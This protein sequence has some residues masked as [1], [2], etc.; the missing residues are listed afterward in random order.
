MI[1]ALNAQKWDHVFFTGSVSVGRIVYEAAAKNLTPVTLELGGKNPTI[2]D[3][4]VDIYLAAK[5]ICWGKFWNAGQTCIAPDYVL[6]HKSIE[7][8]FLEE[9]VKVI[10]QFYGE[11][12]Q[13]SE[14]FARIISKDHTKRLAKLFEQGKVVCGGKIDEAT[15]YVA[16]TILTEVKLDG[17]LMNDEIFGPVL[18]VIPVDSIDAAIEFLDS[19]PLPLALYF[20]GASS[21]T[22]EKVLANTRS[23]AAGMNDVLL[24]FTNSGLPFG[25]VGESGTG[26]YHG[27]RT[28]NTFVHERAVLFST[29]KNWLDLPLRYPPFSSTTKTIVDKVTRSGW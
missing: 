14:S 15:R 7:K 11:D 4:D 10:K 8:S 26:A 6:V 16:P 23:G 24:H 17:E 5:R 20:F 19:R 13:Q 28:F 12:P 1:K 3:S 22:Q 18:P 27:K 25:G 9:C 21:K 2:I 29:T